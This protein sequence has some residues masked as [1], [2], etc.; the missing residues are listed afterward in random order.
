MIPHEGGGE[1]GPLRGQVADGPVQ[2]FQQ[3]R[4]ED[5]HAE[6]DRHL[7]QLRRTVQ[8]QGAGGRQEIDDAEDGR[9]GGG[10]KP[11]AAVEK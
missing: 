1:L 8:L 7:H 4:G 3:G 9:C 5:A 6:K 10:E 2:G 11:G